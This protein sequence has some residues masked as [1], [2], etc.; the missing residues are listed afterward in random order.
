MRLP[1]DN[2]RFGGDLQSL[3]RSLAM[4]LPS[5]AQQINAVSEGR[6]EGS[7]NAQEAPPAKGLHQAGDYIRNSAPRLLGAAGGQYVIKG[8]I[9]VTSG[10]P[11][12]W[13]EDRGATGT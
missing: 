7:H 8:W 13:V 9:C 4:L 2:Y 12:E 3:K 6:L 10:E 11:G 1:T 5:F